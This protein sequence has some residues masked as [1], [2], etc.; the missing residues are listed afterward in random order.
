MSTGCFFTGVVNLSIGASSFFNA[1]FEA[2]LMLGDAFP[3]GLPEEIA[4]SY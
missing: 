4:R 1:F 2:L 3:E